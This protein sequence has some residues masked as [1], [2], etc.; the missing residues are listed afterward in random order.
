MSIIRAATVTIAAGVLAGLIGCSGASRTLPGGAAYASAQSFDQTMALSPQVTA[1]LAPP[2]FDGQTLSTKYA[3]TDKNGVYHTP[4]VNGLDNQFNP[5]VADT[6]TG[7]HGPANSTFDGVPCDVSM[8]R[9][10]HVHVFVGLYVNGTEYAIPRGVGVAEPQAPNQTPILYA[11]NCFYSTHTHDSTGILH[12]EDYN[13]GTLEKPATSTKY[14]IGQVFAVWGIKVT[15]TQFGQFTGNVRVFTSGARYR[16]IDPKN[17]GTVPESD[18]RQWT[19]AASGIPLYNHMVIW[20]L[21]GPNYPAS[22]PSINFAGG[23]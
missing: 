8:S 2:S 18:L 14:T 20:Y 10:Y 23:Y 15:K 12:I 11:T 4:V 6:S 21:V 13:N 3:Y 1:T 16:Y 22:L 7:G 19:G 17:G 9:N 5:T